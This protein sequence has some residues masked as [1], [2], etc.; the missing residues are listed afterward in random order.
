MPSPGTGRFFYASQAV[1]CLAT[2]ISPYGTTRLRAL[3]RSLADTRFSIPQPPGS[4]QAAAWQPPDQTT[5]EAFVI[6]LYLSVRCDLRA[7]SSVLCFESE[8]LRRHSPGV[9]PSHS[10]KARKNELGSS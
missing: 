9:V 4:R 8:P 2:F 3:I 5:T 10:R 1:N 7:R 6:F